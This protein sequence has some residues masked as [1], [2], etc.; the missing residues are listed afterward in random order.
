MEYKSVLYLYFKHIG[1]L[2]FTISSTIFDVIL[3]E[4]L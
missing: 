2:Y 1:K 4:F 3:H